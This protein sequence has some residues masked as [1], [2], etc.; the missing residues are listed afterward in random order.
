MCAY[1]SYMY[2]HV[3]TV[4][5]LYNGPSNP[6]LMVFTYLC[7]QFSPLAWAGLMNSFLM[8][9]IWQKYWISLLRVGD[10][11]KTVASLLDTFS[12]VLWSTL[13]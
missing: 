4:V 8:N 9:G 3:H 7:N 11:K 10:K 12:L 2:T 6:H 5:K 13:S 1:V